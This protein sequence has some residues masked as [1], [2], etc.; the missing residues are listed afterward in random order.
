[1]VQ[2][3]VISLISKKISTPLFTLPILILRGS[4]G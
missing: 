3:L 1:M 2:S 4:V